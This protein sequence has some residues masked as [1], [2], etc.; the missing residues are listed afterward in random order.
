MTDTDDAADVDSLLAEVQTLAKA[1]PRPLGAI[2]IIAGIVHL[3]APR[4]LLRL[5]SRGYNLVL[6]V[7][8]APREGASGRVRALGFLMV[9]AGAHLLYHGGLRPN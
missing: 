2:L 1:S 6:D 9:A 8:L 3:V 7:E 4:V 5:A